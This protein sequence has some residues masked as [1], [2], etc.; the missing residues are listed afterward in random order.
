MNKETRE[1]IRDI[2]IDLRK[3]LNTSNDDIRAEVVQA[4][5]R[6]YEVIDR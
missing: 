2:I 6:L 5:D 4:I 3:A 1:V